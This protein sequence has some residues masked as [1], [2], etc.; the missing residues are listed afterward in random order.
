[1]DFEWN[2]NKAND[3]EQKHGVTFFEACEVFDDD[4]SS[5]APDSDH[6][7]VEYRYLIFGMSKGGKYLVVSYTERSERIR[8]IS[9]REMTPHE[10]Q[11]Y[12]Q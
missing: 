1:M 10:R 6:S 2:P 7:L 3:N 11:A 8:L 4:Y 9:A 12:E 5:S